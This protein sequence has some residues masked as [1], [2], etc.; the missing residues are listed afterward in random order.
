MKLLL[1]L[2]AVLAG[3]FLLFTLGGGYYLYRFAILRKKKKDYWRETLS[4]LESFTQEEREEIMRGGAFMRTH[5]SEVITIDSHDGLKLCGR[6]IAQEKPVGLVIMVHGYQSHPVLDFSCAV[7]P[8]FRYGFSMLMIDQR[9]HGS[10]EGKHIGFGVTE[11]CDLVRWVD[12]ARERWPELPV[13]LDGVS[14]GAATVM[15]GA[16]LGYADNVKAI[17]AD[18]GY[19]SPGAICKKVLYQWF[20]LPPFPIYYGAKFWIRLLAG[21]DLDG[22]SSVSGLRKLEEQDT[23]PCVL[24][25]HGVADDFVPYEMALECRAAL[26][27]EG[28]VWFASSETAGHGRA[29]LKD[30]EKYIAALEEM[31]ACAGIKI[32]KSGADETIAP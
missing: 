27:E 30:R 24:L 31:F 6:L 22:A 19:T 23:R 4:P 25:A 7:E 15:M 29:F 10:S 16:E 2:F 20:K 5:V 1:I 18:C 26:S 32:R 11:R 14:M 28:R 21:Y 13:L 17:I 8:F 9:A 12:Y 3:L